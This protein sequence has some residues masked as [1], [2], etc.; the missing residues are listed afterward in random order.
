MLNSVKKGK[1]VPGTWFRLTPKFAGEALKYLLSDFQ[2]AWAELG[3]HMYLGSRCC[4][5]TVLRTAVGSTRKPLAEALW[6]STITYAS[7][8]GS[9]VLASILN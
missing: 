8:W 2:D 9:R 7:G 5:F 4:R 6:R 3:T 1:N